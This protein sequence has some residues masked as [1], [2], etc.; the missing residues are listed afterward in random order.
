MF[1]GRV[2]NRFAKDVGFLDDL[3]PFQ[4]CEYFLVSQSFSQILLTYSFFQFFWRCTAIILTAV[5]SNPWM[6]IPV[7]I[8]AAIFFTLR[9]Y[10]LKTAREIKRLE[11]IG[12]TRQQSLT[13]VTHPSD[14]SLTKLTCISLSLARSPVYSH[15]SMTLQGLST[16][17]ALK[18]EDIAL[19]FFHKY[20]NE[21]TQVSDC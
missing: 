12:E 6:A 5:S 15:I 7:V 1:L 19:K 10:F 4:F 14:P 20:Q 2:L 18:K 3:L 11:A 17:R 9:Q 16:V 13:T 21:H 8:L